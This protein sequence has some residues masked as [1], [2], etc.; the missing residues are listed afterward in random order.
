MSLGQ[1]FTTQIVQPPVL[2]SNGTAVT[3][4]DSNTFIYSYFIFVPSNAVTTVFS[5]TTAQNSGTYLQ[6][7]AA[8]LS[9]DIATACS[10]IENFTIRN[11]ANS[12]ITV[13][14][15]QVRNRTGPGLNQPDFLLTPVGPV[16]NVQ[17]SGQNNV[18]TKW[19]IRVKR[20]EVTN[21]PP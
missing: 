8:I 2:S 17:I 16:V 15:G 11:S 12:V 14:F 10:L 6:C 4:T 7:E 9:T 20:Q 21:S 3:G 1:T 5:F 13:S 19:N 18:P